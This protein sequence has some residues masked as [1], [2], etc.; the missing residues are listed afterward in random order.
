MTVDV[1]E[2]S[3]ERVANKDGDVA[4]Q[5][6]TGTISVH[7]LH[8]LLGVN[9]YIRAYLNAMMSI[10]ADNHNLS[11]AAVFTFVQASFQMFSQY[12]TL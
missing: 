1:G 5:C 10:L 8:N 7:T 6:A 11:R 12:C 3:I 2:L 4:N 9:G